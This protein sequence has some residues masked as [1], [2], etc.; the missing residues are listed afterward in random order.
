MTL[1]VRRLSY[2]INEPIKDESLS[3][4]L[5]IID[6]VDEGTLFLVS[7]DVTHSLFSSDLVRR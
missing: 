4:F 6:T 2:S 7:L 5:L 1:L 3:R